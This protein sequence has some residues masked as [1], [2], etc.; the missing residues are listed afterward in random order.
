MH[1]VFSTHLHVYWSKQQRRSCAHIILEIPLTL[2]QSIRFRASTIVAILI[3]RVTGSIGATI[4]SYFY[5]TKKRNRCIFPQTKASFQYKDRL[6]RY[7]ILML[8]IRR[9]WDRL[10]FNMGILILVGRHLYTESDPSTFPTVHHWSLS[11][12]WLT[13]ILACLSNYSHD[14]V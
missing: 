9:W 10:I 13:L 4:E 2:G 5:T 12:A 6:S 14:K 3:M 8:K 1:T 7:G 11:L